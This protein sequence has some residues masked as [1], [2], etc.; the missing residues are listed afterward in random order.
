MVYVWV[1]VGKFNV[2]CVWVRVGKFNVVCVSK[3]W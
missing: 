1:R 2:V 3:S